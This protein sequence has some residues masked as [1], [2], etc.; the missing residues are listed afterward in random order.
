MALAQEIWIDG[1][2]DRVA[3]ETEGTLC[4]RHGEEATVES[5]RQ[6]SK[7]I[8]GNQCHKRYT[9]RY[10]GSDY[11]DRGNSWVCQGEPGTSTAGP[12]R[13]RRASWAEGR[14]IQRHR[15]EVCSGLEEWKWSDLLGNR[16]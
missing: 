3:V 8:P 10:M 5:R 9:T 16:G 14:L 11:G 2:S 12:P 13:E 6:V 15:L 4:A 1:L 7:Q